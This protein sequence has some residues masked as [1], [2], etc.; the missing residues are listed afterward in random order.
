MAELVDAW[1]LKSLARVGRPGSSP[2]GATNTTGV[3]MKL[4]RIEKNDNTETV[5]VNPANICCIYFDS[6]V[7]VLRMACGHGIQTKFTDVDHAVDYIQRSSFVAI[8]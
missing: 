6:G 4:V 2:G 8:T 1:D 7:V 3:I 5:I